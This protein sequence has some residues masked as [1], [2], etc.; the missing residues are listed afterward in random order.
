[1]ATFELNNIRKD[2]DYDNGK[3]T[4][5][6]KG[7]EVFSAMAQGK[8]L[9]HISNDKNVIN[10]AVEHIKDLGKKASCGDYFAAAE[11]NALR[12]F[13]IEPLLLEEA[14][15]LGIF[16][17]YQP[18]AFGDSI[19]R[20]TSVMAGEKSRIQAASG[21]LTF[22]QWKVERYAVPSVTISGGYLVDYRA[23]S[24][25]DMARENQG[26]EQV[27]VDIRNQAALYVVKKLYAAIK[28]A[29]GVKFWAEASGITQASLDNIVKAVRRFGPTSIIGSYAA[30]SQVNSFVGWS[31]GVNVHGIS[32][33]AMEEIRR[34]GLVGMY[35][36][37]TVREIA[38]PFNLT[39][40]TG[41]GASKTFVPLLPDGLLFIL[42]TGGR[43]P[44]MTWTRGGLTSMTGND[45]TTGKVMTRFDL[46][47]AADV[48][49][50]HE[51][52]IGLMNDSN[53]SPAADYA[54]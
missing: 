15:L 31:D 50:G 38:N 25:G 30:V 34:D 29:T 14:K 24:L 41:S 19:E 4:A 44:I 39:E 17:T 42:P 20:E 23:I 35:K 13:V 36:G 48:A 16:G 33:A 51:F 46:E 1:M 18:L 37:S 3:I 53:L 11:L 10:N 49:Q 5:N 47:V 40:T 28:N 6:H 8:D 45:V 12:R 22:P 52:E 21:D 32:D 9:S 7:V 54:I 27:R 26:M 2:A 43:S